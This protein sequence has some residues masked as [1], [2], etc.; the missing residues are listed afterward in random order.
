MSAGNGRKK[1]A[2]M[3]KILI[4][5]ERVPWPIQY[6]DALRVLNL[7]KGLIKE[8]ECHLMAFTEDNMAMSSLASAGIFTELKMLPP[9]SCKLSWKRHLRV[10]DA[11]YLRLADHAHYQ[12]VC[13][14]IQDSIDKNDIDVVVAVSI[15]IAEYLVG[16]RGVKKI[17][18]DYDC[19]TL[20]EERKYK[21]ENQNLGLFGSIKK[22]WTTSRIRKQESNLHEV[23][24]LV[25]TIAPEDL[26]RLCLLNRRNKVPIKLLP[27]GINIGEFE[28]IRDLRKIDNA[29]VFWGNLDFPP[30]RTAIEYFFEEIYLPYLKP[31][32]VTLY[33]A[34]KHPG[35]LLEQ[36]EKEHEER[37]L[38]GF[39][40]DLFSFVG[41]IPVMVNPMVMGSGFKN[42]I[43]EAFMLS[44]G[45]VSTPLGMDFIPAKHGE[46][47]LMADQPKDFADAV[48]ELLN[49]PETRT[50]LG[51]NARQL[52]VDDYSWTRV[53]LTWA[54]MVEEM[55]T[56][57][58]I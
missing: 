57:D 2:T 35:P 41:R 50:L 56:Q 39:V 4:L 40:E 9:L 46:H 8:H 27:N 44:M 28:N 22:T 10:S 15:F 31:Y 5:T 55:L 19:R 34:G 7:S 58:C 24:D 29:V 13:G 42:K 17:L 52:I 16:L 6:G 38:L 1:G 30:N 48:L 32:N 18:D 14:M 23:C 20:S 12:H 43:L 25:T 37:I 33:V 49:C 36:R 51:N 54:K 11:R 21:V 3:A 47:F 26:R 53:G 45:V